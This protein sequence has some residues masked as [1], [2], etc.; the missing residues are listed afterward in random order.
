MRLSLHRTG[1]SLLCVGIVTLAT[2]CDETLTVAPVNDVAADVAIVDAI[3]ARAALVGAYDALHN[4]SYYGDDYMFLMDLSADGVIH[5]GT[6]D[7]Y[8]EADQ[9][10][11]TA[12][13]VT[14]E[15]MWEVIYDGIHRT[16]VIIQRV[17]T[18]PGLTEAK[19]DRI[20]GEAHFLRALHYH[21]LV[22]VWGGV[23][24]VTAPPPSINE[25]SQIARS[26]VDEVYAQ[27]LADL[28]AAESLIETTDETLRASRGAVFALR[29]RVL[30]YNEDWAGVVA[31]GDLAQNY[32]YELAESY[33]DL[34]TAD[35]Q[36]T[37]EDILRVAFTPTEFNNAG[38]YYLIVA[39]GRYEV[40]PSVALMCEYDPTLDCSDLDN[41]DV[42]AYAPEDLRGQFNI[43]LDEENQ[44]GTKY[45]TAEGGEDLHIIRFGEVILNKAEA[46][47]RLGGANL[48]LAVDEYNK[49]RVRAGLPSHVWLVD[50]TTQQEV[51]EAIWR[52]RY[53]E[54][55]FE[56]DRWPDLVRTGR[57]AT[58][59]G[60]PP[61]QALY[62]IPENEIDV[63]PNIQQNP[64]Y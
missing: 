54:L 29:S 45:P 64:G 6:F 2:G 19:R 37:D 28:T 56:A 39:G 59:L 31:A 12:D 34:F 47:A 50:V 22:R 1:L 13:N 24:L 55:A 57:A 15:S 38:Y 18:V 40:A 44:Y 4:V 5:V 42:T 53:L 49:I 36:E 41:V 16:N 61:Y 3:S 7:T 30:L 62:P 14:I 35:D 10:R 33:A 32:G 52:E 21:N 60:I 46:L 58:V 26:S 20:T 17:P 25:A 8:L 51:L 48:P 43:A 9:N 27:I 23:P 11:L 63:A